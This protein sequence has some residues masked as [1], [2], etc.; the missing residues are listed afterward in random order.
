MMDDEIVVS[1][2]EYGDITYTLRLPKETDSPT[3]SPGTAL[4][5]DTGAVDESV[6]T[7]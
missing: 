2:W 3:Q 5:G 7:V 4:S 6:T 1:K